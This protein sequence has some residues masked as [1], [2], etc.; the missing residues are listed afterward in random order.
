[1]FIPECDVSEYCG[2]QTH[3]PYSS[4]PHLWPRYHCAWI[5]HIRHKMTYF[6]EISLYSLT[7]VELLVT[8]RVSTPVRRKR[9][10]CQPTLRASI[11]LHSWSPPPYNVDEKDGVLLHSSCA[12]SLSFICEMTI[13]LITHIDVC[14]GVCLHPRR[15]QNIPNASQGEDVDFLANICFLSLTLIALHSC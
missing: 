6:T 12:V 3:S 10:I 15:L 4:S 5:A 9:L 8:V 14:V 1:V 11:S 7:N 13:V 2:F